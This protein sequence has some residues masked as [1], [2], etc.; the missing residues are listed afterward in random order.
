MIGKTVAH[1]EVLDA[2]GEG[3]MGAVYR[4]KDTR[5]GRNVAIKMLANHLIKDDES[6]QRVLTEARATSAMNHPNVCT[7]YDILE[8][9]EQ[10]YIV[11]ECLEGQT[12]NALIEAGPLEADRAIHII[13]QVAAGLGAAHEKNIVHRDIKPANIMIGNDDHAKIMD[14]GIARLTDTDSVTRTGNVIGTLAYMSPQQLRGEAVDYRSDIWSLGVLLFEMLTGKRPFDGAYDAA[15]MYSILNEEPPDLPSNIIDSSADIEQLIRRTLSKDVTQR[16]ESCEAFVRYLKGNTISAP[17]R[18]TSSDKSLLIQPFEYL[19]N[20]EDNKFFC[21]GL[22][23]EL[24]ADLSSVED[25]TVIARTSS[26]LSD[27]NES[28]SALGKELNV[29]F[30]LKGKVRKAEKD[31]RITVQLIEATQEKLLWAEKYKGTL[32]KI[33]E[34]QE[35]VS[36][37]I[38]DALEIKLSKKER[39]HIKGHRISNPKAYEYYL[40]AR[41]LIWSLRENSLASASSYLDKAEDIIGEHELIYGLRGYIAFQEVNVGGKADLSRLKD[42]ESF[43]WKA[44]DMNPDSGRAY[45]VKGLIEQKRGNAGAMLRNLRLATK[46]DPGET[47]AWLWLANVLL[48]TGQFDEA[49]TIVDRIYRIDPLHPTTR[50]LLMWQEMMLGRF[51]IALEISRSY[52]KANPE[53]LFV[54]LFYTWALAFNRQTAEMVEAWKDV[55]RGISVVADI[56]R[57]YIPALEKDK[58]RLVAALTD[59]MITSSKNDEQT[60]LIIA[61]CY[62]L[63]GEKRQALNWLEQA[64]EHGFLNHSFLSE[65]DPLLENIRGEPDFERLMVR[66]KEKLASL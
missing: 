43:A 44:I 13:R 12:L 55:D 23:E 22:T 2:L 61:Q 35:Q 50:I 64:I 10:F 30:V 11:M 52:I 46:L 9:D 31:L 5:L 20:D 53:S 1:F 6:R 27:S 14:F 28:V 38:T 66:V 39:A 15:L 29:G 36:K 26:L 60:P 25:L 7:L 59:D 57:L 56:F 19:S 62:A 33:F 49:A 40:M 21:Q 34:L 48:Q 4:A 3:G 54:R 17:S 51:D 58:A 24:I 8:H 47:E 63:V 37:A 32:D 16:P 45:F 41:S 42:A 65:Y 18:E